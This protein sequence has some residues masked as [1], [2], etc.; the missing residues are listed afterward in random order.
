M[1][2]PTTVEEALLLPKQY[3][4]V[5]ERLRFLLVRRIFRSPGGRCRPTR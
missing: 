5:E 3:G 2:W 1:R 4:I